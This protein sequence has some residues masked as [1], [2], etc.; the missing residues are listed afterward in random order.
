MAC[1]ARVMARASL[2]AIA[3]SLGALAG[4]ARADDA[5]YQNFLLGERAFGIG[6][7]FTATADDAS[8]AFYN[9]AGLALVPGSSISLSLSIYG[10]ERRYVESGHAALLDGEVVRLDYDEVELTTLPTTVGLVQKFG[11]RLVDCHSA[12]R[13]STAGAKFGEPGSDE[14]D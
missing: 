5:N 6:G 7:A 3:V 9:P 11:Q 2:V 12:A 8:G 10:L 1:Y 4:T 13:S 14:P